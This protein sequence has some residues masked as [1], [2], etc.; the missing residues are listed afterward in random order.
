MTKY[1]SYLFL[2]I[3]VS[4]GSTEKNAPE[5]KTYSDDTNRTFEMIERAGSYYLKKAPVNSNP[6]PQITR[7]SK[8]QNTT[9][10]T[11]R[12]YSPPVE[13]ELPKEQP[14]DQS[15]EEIVID[16]K[17]NFAETQLQNTPEKPGPSVPV[18]KKSAAT[19][20]ADERLIEINQNLAFFCMKHRKDPTFGGDEAKCMKFV[21]KSME[22]CQKQHKIVNSKL[23]NCI[24]TKLKKR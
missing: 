3:L 12:I 11:T 23:L 22:N 14:K 4:C 20:R 10:T 9:P 1:F 6:A 18:E 21:N 8:R 17:I 16:E 15:R 7:P 5:S 13:R 19:S 2:L 24:Q